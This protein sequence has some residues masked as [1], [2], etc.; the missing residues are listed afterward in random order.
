ME[1][2]LNAVITEEKN[3]FFLFSSSD[4]LEPS[5]EKNIKIRIQNICFGS[6]DV[7]LSQVRNDLYGTNYK[8]LCL[9]CDLHKV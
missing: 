1:I 6:V 4:K 3:L 9:K 2:I 5:T 7:T 8:I